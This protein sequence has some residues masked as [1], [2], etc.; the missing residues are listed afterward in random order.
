MLQ[1]NWLFMKNNSIR[2]AWN[3][4][5]KKKKKPRCLIWGS[6]WTPWLQFGFSASRWHQQLVQCALR[7]N[8]TTMMLACPRGQCLRWGSYGFVVCLRQHKVFS[9]WPRSPGS[10]SCS[11]IHAV[12]NYLVFISQFPSVSAWYFNPLNCQHSHALTLTHT[13][14][15]VKVSST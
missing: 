14:I 5:E 10:C 7:C 6:E 13:C 9:F 1:E 12:L 2:N 8:A 3:A 4:W 11:K 15:S